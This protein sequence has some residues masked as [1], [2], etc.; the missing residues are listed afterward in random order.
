MFT[1]LRHFMLTEYQKPLMI[2]F[3]PT[4]SKI[5]LLFVFSLSG[6]LYTICIKVLYTTYSI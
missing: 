5:K 6:I 1:H 3:G 4:Q 2:L